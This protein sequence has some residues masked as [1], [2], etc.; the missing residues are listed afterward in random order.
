MTVRLIPT[1]SLAA[2]MAVLLYLVKRARRTSG[3]P[4]TQSPQNRQI[5]QLEGFRS[6]RIPAVML[7]ARPR[8][9]IDG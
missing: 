4:A 7:Q 1:L 3:L 8:V 9:V 5:D 6:M 2:G